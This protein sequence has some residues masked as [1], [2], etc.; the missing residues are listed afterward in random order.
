MNLGWADYFAS[1]AMT[2]AGKLEGV[3]TPS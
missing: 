2:E 1:L 3:K